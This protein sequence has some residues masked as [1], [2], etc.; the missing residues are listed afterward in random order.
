MTNKHGSLHVIVG[1]MSSGKSEELIRLLN[2]VA[3]ARQPRVVVKPSAD[4]RSAATTIT[5]RAGLT[6]SAVSVSD[7]AEILALVGGFHDG[8]HLVIGLDEVQF[9]PPSIVGVVEDLV[10]RG[11]RVIAAGLDTD[12]RGQPFGPVPNLLAVADQVTKCTA[13][14]ARCGAP[15]TRTQLLVTL[16]AGISLDSPVFIGGDEKYEA[17]CRDCHFVPA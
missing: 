2:R 12:Y 11:H 10:R 8:R 17:R 9:F 1:C 4:T 13:V 5:S 16:P 7:P 14:C 6:H 3:L 15:A